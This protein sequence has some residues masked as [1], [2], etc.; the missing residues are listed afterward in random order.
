MRKKK[1]KKVQLSQSPP[2]LPWLIFQIWQIGIFYEPAQITKKTF[3]TNF[4]KWKFL[5][6]LRNKVVKVNFV[7]RQ[8]LLKIHLLNWS[9]VTLFQHQQ[10][11]QITSYKILKTLHQHIAC[12]GKALPKLQELPFAFFV[13]AIFLDCDWL[14]PVTCV[15]CVCPWKWNFSLQPHSCKYNRN[16]PNCSSCCGGHPTTT[17]FTKDTAVSIAT[18]A[19]PT[20]LQ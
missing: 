8:N 13:C 17:C 20:K 15:T 18:C 14:S 16:T 12:G 3:T 6:N 7:M 5:T 10:L 4:R 9:K 19:N 1:K 2:K 11:L